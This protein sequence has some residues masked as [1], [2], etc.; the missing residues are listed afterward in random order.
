MRAPIQAWYITASVDRHGQAQVDGARKGS[1][2]RMTMMLPPAGMGGPSVAPTMMTM[3]LPDAVVSDA[4][5]SHLGDGMSSTITNVVIVA[6]T[7]KLIGREVNV[8]AD[9]IAMLSLSQIEPPASCQDLP[10]ILNLLVPDCS[11]AGGALSAADMAYLQALYKI[12]TTA[13][14]AG[15][16]DEMTYQMTKA[17]GAGR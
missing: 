13:K 4:T 5:D 10:T 11:R 8:L 17:L 3:N 16:R 12:T 9:Y 14:V 1:S 7:S 2:L 6:D 15:Q